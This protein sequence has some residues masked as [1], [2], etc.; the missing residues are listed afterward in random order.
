MRTQTFRSCYRKSRQR[1]VDQ[2]IVA[3]SPARVANLGGSPENTSRYGQL[4]GPDESSSPETAT[5]VTAVT[6][7]E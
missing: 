1:H 5:A 3:A 6:F 2:L 4:S 7:A